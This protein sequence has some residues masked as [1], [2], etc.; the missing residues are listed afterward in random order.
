ME[1]R[2]R[3]P[4]LNTQGWSGRYTVEDKPESGWNE[5]EV[6]DIS[7]LGIGVKLFST[8]S[9]QLVGHRLVVHVQAPVGESVSIR[10]LG[11]VMNVR[12]EPDGAIRAG[13]EFVGLS[14]TERTILKLMELMKVAW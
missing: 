3:A 10:L 13:L 1:L 9:E 5:C 14:E 8:E 4:R 11:R 12:N 6:I 7:V 2:R